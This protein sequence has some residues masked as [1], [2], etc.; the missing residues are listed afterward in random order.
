MR[1]GKGECCPCGR[2]SPSDILDLP[3][4]HSRPGSYR[5]RTL[6]PGRMIVPRIPFSR[7][8]SLTLVL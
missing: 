8:I 4:S 2:H 5:T 1:M 3:G 7:W 6:C